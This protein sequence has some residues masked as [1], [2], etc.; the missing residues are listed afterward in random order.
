M[1]R[2]IAVIDLGSNSFRLVVFT[3]A[4]EWWKR[5]DE[6]YEPVRVGE[7]QEEGGP[8]RPEPMERALEAIELFAQFCRASGIERIRPLATSAIREASNR[9]EFLAAAKERS[10]LDVEVLSRAEEAHYGYLAAVNSTTLTDG[11]AL[12]IGGGSMQLTQVAARRARS[13][14][15][16]RLGA[17][18]TTE[19]FLP[20]ERVKPKQIKALREH[21]R[22]E[23]RSAPWLPGAPGRL[24]GIGGT[25]R[26]LAGITMTAE[27]LPTFGVQGF[28]LRRKALDDLIDKL[29]DLTPAE[30]RRVPGLKPER[31]DLILAGAVVVQTVMEVC[32]FEAMEVTEAGLREGVFFEE[33]LEGTDPPL[34]PDVREASVRNLAAQYHPETAHTEHVAKLAL[35]MWDGL[36]D[37]G[38]HPGRAD[39]R[40]LLWAAAILHDVGTAVD[41]DDHH[42]HSRYLILNAG[43]PGFSPRETAIIGQVARYHRKGQPGLREFAP[44]G[45]TGDDELLARCAA[46]LRVAEQ[47]ERARDQSVSRTSIAV[48]D[49]TV[50]LTLKSAGD[51]DL[52]RW[53]AQRQADV[54]RKAFDRELSVR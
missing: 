10:G 13:A 52:S 42:K 30:R 46:L 31:A 44:L 14:Q 54:F 49:G 21:V 32:G 40:E 34:V 1:E 3:H 50:E 17:V 4:G 36:S 18:V 27:G 22:D 6:I 45:R 5:T 19:R 25:V 9:A 24:A 8:L 7:Q 15:S 16:W 11:I 38:L 51:V 20:T 35:E 12:D 53:G 29:A 33:L 26:N 47:L 43:L 2:R 23:L 41:Y 28:E 37:A 48:H 39:E